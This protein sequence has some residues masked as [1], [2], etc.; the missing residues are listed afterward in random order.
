MTAKGK[1]VSSVPPV[2]RPPRTNIDWDGAALR[3]RSTGKPVLAAQHVRHSL[4]QSVRQ[5]NRAPFVQHDGRIVVMLRNSK[6]EGGVRYGDV[7]FTWEPTTT[8]EGE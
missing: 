5:R 6:V 2:G 4:V 7:Y 1:V 8:E 3:A